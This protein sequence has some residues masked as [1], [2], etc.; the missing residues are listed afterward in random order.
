[1]GSPYCGCTLAARQA[2][3]LRGRCAAADSCNPPMENPYCSCKLTPRPGGGAGDIA[4]NLD[5]VPRGDDYL[6]G[7]APPNI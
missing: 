1:M 4:Y 2:L 3:T 5:I 6:L 7:A